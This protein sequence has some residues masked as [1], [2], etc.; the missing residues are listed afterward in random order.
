MSIVPDAALLSAPVRQLERGS[1]AKTPRFDADDARRLSARAVIRT[2]RPRELAAAL[3][4]D[5]H[6]IA[7]SF[8]ASAPRGEVYVTGADSETVALAVSRVAR[9]EDLPIHSIDTSW[10]P[11]PQI[12]GAP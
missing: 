12:R 9:R 11:P 8:E 6:I 7:V 2:E 3:S 5:P 1:W 4:R 10:S